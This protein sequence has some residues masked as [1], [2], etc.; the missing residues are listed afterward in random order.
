MYRPLFTV[1]GGPCRGSLLGYGGVRVGGFPNRDPPD[2]APSLTEIPWTKTPPQTEILLDRD[3]PLPTGC[4]TGR[5]II[6]IPPV[7]R[8]THRRK[9]IT[10]PQTSFAG[11]NNGH[12]LKTLRV[13]RPQYFLLELKCCECKLNIPCTLDS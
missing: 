6:Q 1:R 5:D 3:N 11:D 8:M 10:L 7:N 12:G 4:Q 2:R 13:N 9:N